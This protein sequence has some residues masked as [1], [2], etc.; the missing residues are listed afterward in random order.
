MESKFIRR[1]FKPF[2]DWS[3][4]KTLIELRGLYGLCNYYR[5]FVKG[6]SQL[7][8]PLNNLTKKGAFRWLD[9]AQCTFDRLKEIMSTCPMLA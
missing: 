4:P 6:F 7:G 5:R 9:E 2:M 8:A 3:P 1:T